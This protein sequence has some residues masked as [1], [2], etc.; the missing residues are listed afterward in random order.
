MIGFDDFTK[1]NIE[2]HNT[3]IFYSVM[4]AWGEH[5]YLGCKQHQIRLLIYIKNIR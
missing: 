4:V 1:E 3:K 2:E 5:V